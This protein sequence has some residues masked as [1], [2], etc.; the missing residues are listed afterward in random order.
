MTEREFC[1]LQ[2]DKWRR[3]RQEIEMTNLVYGSQ[4]GSTI[5]LSC[6]AGHLATVGD[7]ESTV[8]SVSQ[9]QGAVSASNLSPQ[10]WSVGGRGMPPD[11]SAE[12]PGYVPLGTGSTPYQPTSSYST[13]QGTIGGV[14]FDV[15]LPIDINFSPAGDYQGGVLVPYPLAA[16]FCYPSAGD[17]GVYYSDRITFFFKFTIVEG[18]APSSSSSVVSSSS[19]VVSSSSGIS[20]SSG[21]SSS[22][23]S[24]TSSVSSASSL[25]SS[26]S[27]LSSSPPSSASSSSI[28]S[29]SALSSSSLNSL[30]SMSSQSFGGLSSVSQSSIN[31]GNCPPVPLV[32]LPSNRFPD[33]EIPRQGIDSL[34]EWSDAWRRSQTAE[35]TLFDRL[36][37]GLQASLVIPQRRIEALG[38]SLLEAWPLLE[39]EKEFWVLP[40]KS[41]VPASLQN[42][43]SL[44]PGVVPHV[45]SDT[46]LD[47]PGIMVGDGVSYNGNYFVS[48]PPVLD[49]QERFWSENSGPR[50]WMDS[51]KNIFARNLATRLLPGVMADPTFQQGGYIS[52]PDLPIGDVWF[53]RNPTPIYPYYGT[54]QKAI[55]W[56]PS[57]PLFV[58]Q[59]TPGDV[60][61]FAYTSASEASLDAVALFQ[62]D[63]EYE[64]RHGYMVG[65]IY[66]CESDQSWGAP[67][68][69]FLS[70]FSMNLHKRR[71]G[72]SHPAR[73]QRLQ[74]LMML[75]SKAYRSRPD[76]ISWTL[77]AA[78]GRVTINTLSDGASGFTLSNTTVIFPDLDEQQKTLTRF[79]VLAIPGSG[80]A[81]SIFSYS[82][83][84]LACQ[85][86]LDR[87]IPSQRFGGETVSA[88]PA[89]AY[90]PFRFSGHPKASGIDRHDFPIP[91]KGTLLQDNRSDASY[92]YG[93]INRDSLLAKDILSIIR[94]YTDTG[95]QVT[96]RPDT[97][98]DSLIYLSRSTA[99]KTLTCVDAIDRGDINLR[100]PGRAVPSPLLYS[101]LPKRVMQWKS[102]PSDSRDA[103]G[104]PLDLDDTKIPFT[105][106]Q[107]AGS[108]LTQGATSTLYDSISAHF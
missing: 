6:I 83:T 84:V 95:T 105:P 43:V 52:V 66:P 29:S 34:P 68:K 50:V 97:R 35:R 67:S 82:N 44:A 69:G 1:P 10:G 51:N 37:R 2:Y 12:Y 106:T 32:S 96:L 23:S 18:V 53:R 65:P 22:G 39:T 46:R 54:W 63:A 15:T 99:I 85:T 7:Y 8:W 108:P 78:L 5:S 104:P 36:I 86:G 91:S 61:D 103:V 80:E 74:S 57:S 64:G 71:K 26:N 70:L 62:G 30:P 58:H 87:R 76:M 59:L 107:S 102:A 60:V 33:L 25:S 3:V 20:S 42:F 13:S 100:V 4:R 98:P 56:S 90:S 19:S 21:V 11:A 28:S 27:S 55:A 72:E 75:R 49:F 79:G 81:A 14:F 17:Y 24:T 48:L 101:L 92:C 77:A 89:S 93:I 73:L 38:T 45:I 94:P 31:T 41:Q 16:K 40:P 9:L 47:T 88:T